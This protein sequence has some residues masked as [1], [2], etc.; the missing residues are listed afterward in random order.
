VAQYPQA[1]RQVQMVCKHPQQIID[2]QRQI[3]DLQ[4]RQFV[5]R[6]C[7]HTELEHEIQVLRDELD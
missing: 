1:I 4:T 3:T 7:Y 6:Q 5:P 2:L